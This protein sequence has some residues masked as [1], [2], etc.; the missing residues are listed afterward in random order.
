MWVKLAY[1]LN[2]KFPLSLCNLP[3]ENNL[4]RNERVWRDNDMTWLK[5]LDRFQH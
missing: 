5:K 4:F 1:L 2:D 3:K